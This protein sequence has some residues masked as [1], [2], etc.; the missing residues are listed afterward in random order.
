M[1]NALAAAAGC[2]SV[3][4]GLQQ[5]KQGL[6]KMRP[7]IGRL[8]PLKGRQGSLVIDDSYNANPDSLKAGLDVLINCK[9][10]PWVVLGA[11]G[12]QGSDSQNI[13]KKMGVDIK[14]AGVKR[15]MAV[16]EDAK[17]TVAEFGEGGQYFAE[18]AELITKLKQ[19]LNGEETILIKGSRTQKMENVVEALVENFRI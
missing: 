7:V 10:T 2:L 13:H 12:E 11:F 1:T 18:Q 17:N 14:E 8:Q 4:I 5:I 16:G 15:L 9:G 6:E 3:G 19:S